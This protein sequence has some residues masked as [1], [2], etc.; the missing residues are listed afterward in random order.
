MD[1]LF[2]VNPASGRE[3][4]A[5]AVRAAV[6]A[7]F[8]ARPG[9]SREVAETRCKGHA[10]ALVA[11]RVRAGR[12]GDLRVYACGGDGTL[13]EVVSAAAGRPNVEVACY[14]CGTGNDFIRIFPEYPRT[15]SPELLPRLIEGVSRPLDAIR[16]NGVYAANVCCVGLDANVGVDML[17]FKRLPVVGG[18]MSYISSLAVNML[19]R[20]KMGHRV[21]I[22]GAVYGG[23]HLLISA[24]NGQ[25]YGG[26]F[27]P[28]K[29]SR[30]DD[31]LL[32]IVLVKGVSRLRI[33][34]LIRHYA[35][36]ELE[37]IASL[38]ELVRGKRLV[39]ESES[40]GKPF[41]LIYDGETMSAERAE[42][43]IAPGALRFVTPRAE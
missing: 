24:M 35:K 15:A 26:G 30:P 22:D 8:A 10:A 14:P 9:E 37:K 4:A 27:R 17:R 34:F 6:S 39:V 41:A 32:D 12:P 29:D 21:E 25:F 3:N 31:G 18:R 5:P 40:P 20:V 16:L 7:Y 33:P 23:T 42:I 19:K 38:A 11:E 13:S 28:A 36:G 2:V 1:H 43:E